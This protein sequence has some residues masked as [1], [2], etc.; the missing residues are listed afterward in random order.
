MPNFSSLVD[1]M[2]R[3]LKKGQ[4]WA[5]G[6]KQD[7]SLLAC[8]DFSTRFVL[9]ANASDYGLGA[10]LTQ[11]QRVIASA[12]PKLLKAEFNYSTTEKECLVIVWAIR[13]MRC[14]LEATGST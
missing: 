4:K 8:P 5:W 14:Y 7:E 12:S 10:V 6:E 1:P 3:L 2:T 13:K 11:E 9:Q